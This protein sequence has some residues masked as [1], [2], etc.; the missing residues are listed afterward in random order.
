MCM[1][2]ACIFLRTEEQEEVYLSLVLAKSRLTSLKEITLPRLELMVALLG[3]RLYQLAIKSLDCINTKTYFWSDSS[4]VLAWLKKRNNWSVFVENR[5]KEIQ[6]YSKEGCWKH[7]PGILNPADLFSR[8]WYPLPLLKYQWWT[9]PEFLKPP[10]TWPSN[11]PDF[12][13]KEIDKERRRTVISEK[14]STVETILA[15][16]ASRF[17]KYSMIVRTVAWML[18]FQPT[19]M[20]NENRLTNIFAE[21]FENAEKSLFL[22]IQKDAFE[23]ER[24]KI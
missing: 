1:Y 21:E 6:N 17:S 10:E 15:K 16:L 11:D 20:K 23:E 14:N 5:V 12:D 24:K 7:I 4:A 13:M 18:R 9:G 2:G 19:Y 3:V 8:G 22:L